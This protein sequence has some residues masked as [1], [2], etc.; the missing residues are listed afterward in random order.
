[1]KIITLFTLKIIREHCFCQFVFKYFILVH[2]F[3]GNI[4]QIAQ[5]LVSSIFMRF[6]GTFSVVVMS[7]Y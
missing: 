2:T 4:R 5:D 1:M 6:R 3:I 7:S